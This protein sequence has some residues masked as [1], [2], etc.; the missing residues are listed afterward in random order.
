MFKNRTFL[1]TQKKRF[2]PKVSKNLDTD[3]K[4]ILL[5]YQNNYVERLSVADNAGKVL[6]F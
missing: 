6:T 2:F 4:I 3:L 5:D 1:Y